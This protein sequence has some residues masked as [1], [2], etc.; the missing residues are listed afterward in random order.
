MING[1]IEHSTYKKW[2][3]KLSCDKSE[4]Q[5]EIKILE[6]DQNGR[7]T[8]LIQ[9][10]PHLMNMKMMY[11][12]ADLGQK[13]LFLKVVFKDT[14]TY[15]GGKY[16][17]PFTQSGLCSQLYDYQ[18]KRTAPGGA[19]RRKFGRNSRVYPRRESNPYPHFCRQDF[20]SCASTCSA[21]RVSSVKK[22]PSRQKR[23]GNATCLR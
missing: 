6:A 20:K 18:E 10:F 9:L 3:P 5:E 21:T 12:K 4:I 15:S 11:Y 19:V 22:N 23:E 1:E 17:T 7:W 16:R 13:H 2:Y 8:A 14:L